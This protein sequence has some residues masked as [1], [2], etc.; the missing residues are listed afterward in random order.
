MNEKIL[1]LGNGYIGK[2]VYSSLDK[3][4]DRRIISSGMVNYHDINT[5]KKYLFNNGI[6]HVVNCSG[7]TGRPNIDEAEKK[8]SLCWDLNVTSPL[9]IA[10]ICSKIGKPLIHINSGCIYTGYEKEY[11]ENDEPNFGLFNDES[12]FYSKTK[13]AFELESRDCFFKLLR[14]RMP[15]SSVNDE[16]SFLTKILNYDNLIDY[17]NSKTDIEDLCNVIDTLIQKN[18]WW[19]TEQDIYNVVNSDP[20]PTSQVIGI[21]KDYGIYNEN[22]K[23][24]TMDQLPI[25][26]GRSNCILDNGKLREIYDIQSEESALRKILA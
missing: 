21:M 8:K 22:W 25:K 2:H 20:L 13:H 19:T 5:F 7:F 16:R 14:I 1:I 15:L 12:S 4:Y 23:F 17:T 6:T 11:R 9:K 10:R 3:K 26:A 24:V 18:D